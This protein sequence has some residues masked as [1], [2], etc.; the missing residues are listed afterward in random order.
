MAAEILVGEQLTEDMIAAGEHVLGALDRAA[1][2]VKSAF[3]L[4]LPDQQ[5]WRLFLA[6]AYV[7]QQG[8]KA[9]YRRVLAAIKKLP[10]EV[11]R[12]D[13]KDIT[14]VEET[15]PLIQGLGVLVKTGPGKSRIRMS[16]NVVN[17]QFIEDALLYRMT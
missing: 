7:R 4:W 8:P 10:A 12:V 13:I 16:R 14:V 2:P 11:H 6:S 5:V 17:G 3:W 9:V 15:H 1:L